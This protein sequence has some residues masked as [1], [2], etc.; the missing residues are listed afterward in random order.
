MIADLEAAEAAAAAAAAAEVAA[1]AGEEESTEPTGN[2]VCMDNDNGALDTYGEGCASYTAQPLYCGTNYDNN[3]FT[4]NSMCCACGGGVQVEVLEE[5]PSDEPA[6]PAACLSD[7]ETPQACLDEWVLDFEFEVRNCFLNE[8][9]RTATVN[10]SSYQ[11]LLYFGGCGDASVDIWFDRTAEQWDD[12]L[13]YTGSNELT[14]QSDEMTR[15]FNL[16]TGGQ[17]VIGFRLPEE[18]VNEFSQAG[19][20]RGM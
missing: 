6:A 2:F 1:N 12:I 11:Y 19:A 10:G 4:A 17:D 18:L 20:A 13:I 9:R 7:A 15:Y 16:K 3:D 8:K 5:E 14:D